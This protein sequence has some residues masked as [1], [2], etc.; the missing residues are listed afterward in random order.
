M[1]LINSQTIQLFLNYTIQA[2]G[3][4]IR[5]EDIFREYKKLYLDSTIGYAEKKI[6]L[7]QMSEKLNLFIYEI[8]EKKGNMIQGEK[9]GNIFYIQNGDEYMENGRFNREKYLREGDGL[10]L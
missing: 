4:E 6:K 7:S 3:E 8:Y 10:F 2:N 5:G 9:F 1:Q